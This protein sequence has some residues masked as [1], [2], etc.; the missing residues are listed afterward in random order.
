MLGVH[1]CRLPR[2]DPEVVRVEL[3]DVRQESASRGVRLPWPRHRGVDEPLDLEPVL[4]DLPDEVTPRLQRLPQPG[5]I[6][7]PTGQ[8]AP[9][10]HDRER[11]R[12]C[13]HVRARV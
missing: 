11:A 1:L 6:H 3:R 7:D 12:V 8:S 2:R 9:Q 13:V 4:R 5:Q 10:T